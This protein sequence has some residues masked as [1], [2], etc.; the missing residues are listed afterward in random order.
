MNDIATLLA[1]CRELGAELAP[2]PDG[3]L[4]VRAPAPLPE[5]LRAAL[6]QRRT[7]VLALMAAAV[8]SR[9][10]ETQPASPFP[11]PQC[12][13]CI[14]LAPLDEHAPARFW[15]CSGCGVW[16]ATRDGTTHPIVWVSTTMGL[17]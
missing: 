3:K 4:K 1:R 13:G 9:P 5:D 7:E 16:G 6:K 14:Q 8:E 11:C 12:G 2:T 15:T 10:T 17:Q